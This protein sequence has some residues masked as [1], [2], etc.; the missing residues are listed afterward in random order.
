LKKGAEFQP[1][2]REINQVFKFGAVLDFF[3]DGEAIYFGIS[4]E[5][6]LLPEGGGSCRKTSVM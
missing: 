2:S 6:G 3:R 4:N 5:D 1:F